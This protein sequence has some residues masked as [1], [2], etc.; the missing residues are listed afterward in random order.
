MFD[1][2]VPLAS[3]GYIENMG[4][5]GLED[6]RRCTLIHTERR[7][8]F[9]SNVLRNYGWRNECRTLTMQYT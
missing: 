4:I 5:R 9:W 2:E 7:P 3:P 6:L 1:D 8:Y